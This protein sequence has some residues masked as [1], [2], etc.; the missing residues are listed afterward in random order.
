MDKLLE[1]IKQSNTTQ[2][3][4]IRA[5]VVTSNASNTD[6][7]TII[8]NIDNRLNIS[9]TTSSLVETSTIETTD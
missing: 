3:R 8:T 5:N 1:K 6:K 7:S 4:A 9:N 2:L